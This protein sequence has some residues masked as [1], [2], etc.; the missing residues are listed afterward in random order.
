M[1]DMGPTSLNGI[2]T[3]VCVCAFVRASTG[4]G[5]HGAVTPQ[6]AAGVGAAHPSAS[7]LLDRWA[8]VGY[9]VRD[10]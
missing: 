7:F 1:R 6:L 2:V 5:Q 3:G 9:A 10:P 8:E 4:V